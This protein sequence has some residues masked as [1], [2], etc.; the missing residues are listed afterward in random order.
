[1]N[2]NTTLLLLLPV[3]VWAWQA[4]ASDLTI[5]PDGGLPDAAP[6]DGSGAADL[7][8]ALLDLNP[9]ASPDLPGV[10]V[11]GLV[12][13]K[14][15]KIQI[16][17]KQGG[18][19]T[20][21]KGQWFKPKIA[22]P[23]PL[24]VTQGLV[25]TT[26][27]IYLLPALCMDSEAKTPK[28]VSYYSRPRMAKTPLQLCQKACGASQCCAWAC[29][30]KDYTDLTITILHLPHTG[31]TMAGAPFT[32]RF[33]IHTAGI[34]LMREDFMVEYDYC[35]FGCSTLGKQV[36]T[37]DLA[38]GSSHTFDSMEL[39]LPADALNGVY[40]IEV[41]VDSTDRVKETREDNN[42]A[43]QTIMVTGGREP[44]AGRHE[45][46]VDTT[47]TQSDWRLVQ[48]PDQSGP[49]W[50]GAGRPKLEGCSVGG[51]PTAAWLVLG[52][53]GLLAFRW[54]FRE[55]RP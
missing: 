20:V 51:A 46:M 49:S 9:C 4:Q 8:K 41:K 42:T 32:I 21:K 30:K 38:A 25:A 37:M 48:D 14:M 28:A 47:I 7:N 45:M 33:R 29:Q 52:L 40:F 55:P 5:D 39:A 43:S 12:V 26:P 11:V 15:L 22:G 6:T 34:G 3:L 19:I 50:P 24:M 18:A 2:R 13:G 10:A 35:T 1:M 36:I 16:T 17:V 27:G 44:D 53:L 23:Q 54:R 31:A